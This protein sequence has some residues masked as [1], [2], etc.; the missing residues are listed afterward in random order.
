MCLGIPMQVVE[1][2]TGFAICAQA[3]KRRRIDTMLVGD[4]PPGTW[5]LVFIDAARKVISAEDATRITDAL[6][7]LDDVMAGGTGN[8]DAMF[9]DIIAAAGERDRRE[10]R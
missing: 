3:G 6:A 8:I 4:Q 7:A 9:A 1:S 5:L 10:G 2:G